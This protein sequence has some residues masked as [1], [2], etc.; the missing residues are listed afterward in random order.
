MCIFAEV[1]NAD[2]FEVAYLN[3]QVHRSFMVKRLHI[4]LFTFMKK[5]FSTT[6]SVVCTSC[7]PIQK[8]FITRCAPNRLRSVRKAVLVSQSAGGG[9]DDT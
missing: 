9:R 5:P 1:V 8:S 3:H 7:Y 2:K 6:S 4:V